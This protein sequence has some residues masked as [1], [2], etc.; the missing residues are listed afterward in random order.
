MIVELH[1]NPLKSTAKSGHLASFSIHVNSFIYYLIYYILNTWKDWAKVVFFFQI[2]I[3]ICYGVAKATSWQTGR[4]I[5]WG[6]GSP[7]TQSIHLERS[8]MSGLA[9]QANPQYVEILEREKL[10]Q[11]RLR[12]RSTFAVTGDGESR[13]ATFWFF[14]KEIWILVLFG[15][16]IYHATSCLVRLLAGLTK[17]LSTLI[18]FQTKTE[19]FCSV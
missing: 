1:E 10:L 12:L 2:N 16:I 17:A 19:L 15:S 14:L 6:S 4:T 8:K 5:S 9:S 3:V 18:R 7:Q 11:Q 13:E